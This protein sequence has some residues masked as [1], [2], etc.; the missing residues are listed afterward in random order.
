MVGCVFRKHYCAHDCVRASTGYAFSWLVVVT[1][2]IAA[3]PNWCRIGSGIWR[4]G[5]QCVEPS[6]CGSS[7]I[8]AGHECC[9]CDVTTFA[10]VCT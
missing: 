6:I 5:P 4:R 3:V 8:Y 2:I 10:A 1:G 7:D 9:C